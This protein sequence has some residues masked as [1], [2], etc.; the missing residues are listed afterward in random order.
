MFELSL[1]EDEEDLKSDPTYTPAPCES[2][3]LEMLELEIDAAIEPYWSEYDR[4]WFCG[5][6]S[7]PL[8]RKEP[9]F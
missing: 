1:L 3:Q 9:I 8:N 5:R 4:M 6:C 2:C 7:R